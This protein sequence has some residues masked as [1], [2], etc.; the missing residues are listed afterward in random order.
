MKNKKKKGRMLAFLLLALALCVTAVPAQVGQAAT[1]STVVVNYEGKAYYLNKSAI[2]LDQVKKRTLLKR[3]TKADVVKKKGLVGDVYWEMIM[4][5]SMHSWMTV[6][7]QTV[8]HAR[9]PELLWR[10]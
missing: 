7:R 8:T 5:T 4:D 10:S 6:S 1:M 9:P 3:K 2:P